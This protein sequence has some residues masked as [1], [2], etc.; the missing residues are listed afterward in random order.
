[1][2]QEHLIQPFELFF[3]KSFYVYYLSCYLNMILQMHGKQLGRLP[4]QNNVRDIIMAQD[5]P[6]L[7]YSLRL[8]GGS[9]QV[10]TMDMCAGQ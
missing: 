10:S 5:K 3:N 7:S 8:I 4:L 6:L 1:M 2:Q 9:L